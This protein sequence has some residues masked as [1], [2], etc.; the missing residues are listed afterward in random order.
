[1]GSAAGR[2]L[3]LKSGGSRGGPRYSPQSRRG[4]RGSTEKSPASRADPLKAPLKND[5]K[6][7][8]GSEGEIVHVSD[9]ALMAAACRALETARA[10]GF[11][12]DP[13]AERLAGARGMAIA[14]ALPR[15]EIMCFGVGV[16]SRFLDALVTDT[17]TDEG[18]RTVVSVGCGLDTRPWRL[19]LPGDLRWIEVDFTAMLDYKA[20]LLE[21]ERPKC[22]VDRIAADL[23][24]ASQRRAVFAAAGGAAGLMITEGLLMYLAAETVEGLAAEPGAM[25]GIRYWLTDITSPLMSRIVGMDSFQS[26]Q[27]MRAPSHL[28]GTKILETLDRNGWISKKQRSYVTDVWEFAGERIRAARAKAPAPAAQPPIP[29][30]DPSGV[31]L[32]ARK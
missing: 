31:H 5:N 2:V 28:D 1:M 20:A 25:S 24:D 12:R 6:P 16:R 3:S 14:R 9:T 30:E 15:M 26:V 11:V 8:A 27:N 23:N 19:D 21:A 29:P 7:M 17:V 22:R 13:F 4:H 10:D 18:I 32:F